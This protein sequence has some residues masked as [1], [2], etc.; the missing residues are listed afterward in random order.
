MKKV[1]IPI[2]IAAICLPVALL[3]VLLASIS[4]G[5]EVY[6][7]VAYGAEDYEIM[8]VYIPD[9]VDE[10][11]ECGA[12]IFIHG[13]SWQGG[14]KREEE[15]RCKFLASRGY[16]AATVNYALYSKDNPD[17]FSVD[18]VMDEIDAAILELLCFTSEL[19]ISL[20]RVA[21]SGYSAGA[22]LSMMYAFSRAYAAPLDVVFSANLAGPADIST[23]IWGEDLA[24]KIGTMLSGVELTRDMLE[25]GEADEILAE[26]SPVTH[27]DENT[28]P[29]LF[30]YGGKDTTVKAENGDSLVRALEEHGVEYEYIFMPNSD[31]SLLQNIFKHLD[32]MFTLSE[33]C[34]KYF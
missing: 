2:I 13:G 11:D 10:A 12:V 24:L 22:H 4:F 17:A 6:R 28:P 30:V 31:H 15:I 3:A 27:V 25:S 32:Y 9:G 33:W 23:E 1:I 26:I 19:D 34:E 16:I 5:Y 21:I 7:D 8:D 20:T 29:V 14:D 18:V